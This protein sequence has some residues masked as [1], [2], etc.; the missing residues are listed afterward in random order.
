MEFVPGIFTIAMVGRTG[1]C[2]R[3][4]QTEFVFFPILKLVNKCNKFRKYLSA[5]A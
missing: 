1:N 3:Y 4:L 2:R 5:S